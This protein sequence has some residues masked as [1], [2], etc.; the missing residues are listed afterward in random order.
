MRPLARIGE[1]GLD[2]GRHDNGDRGTEAELHA[3]FFRHAE[4]AEDFVEHGHDD[5]TAAD[6]KSACEQ[7]GDDAA[8]HDGERKEENLVEPDAEYHLPVHIP[9]WLRVPKIKF[10][11]IGGE[12]HRQPAAR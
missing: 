2:R 7:S 3:H 4:H 9:Q 1:I 12:V 11:N 6:A 10:G 5:R 8:D